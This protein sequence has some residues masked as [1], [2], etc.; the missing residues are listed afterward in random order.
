MPAQMLGDSRFGIS[1][2]AGIDGR[3]NFQTVGIQIIRR[4]VG[5]TIF[6]APAV[7]RIGCPC[8]RVIN[9]LL[10]LPTAIIF[11]VGFASGHHLANM[12]A[13]IWSDTGLMTDTCEMGL[14]RKCL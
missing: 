6:P 8:N 11:A 2:H 14:N 10:P 13:E 9:K 5:F 1:L 12:L 7:K 3:I 4:T